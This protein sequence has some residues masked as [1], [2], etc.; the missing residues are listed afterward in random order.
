MEGGIARGI[1]E[2]SEG[3]DRRR[4][5]GKDGGRDRGRDTRRDKGRDRKKELSVGKEN[6]N[7]SYCRPFKRD[8]ETVRISPGN[9]N[10]KISSISKPIFFKY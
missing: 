8:I 1:E 3:K 10:S 5:R 6:S 4:D 9:S 7:I 2:V